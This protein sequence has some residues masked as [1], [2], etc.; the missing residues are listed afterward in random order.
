MTATTSSG[1]G[2]ER[3]KG[4]AGP[5][6]RR[7]AR[8]GGGQAAADEAEAVAEVEAEVVDTEGEEGAGPSCCSGGPEALW[9]EEEG[10]E[11]GE[12]EAEA[13]AKAPRRRLKV[14]HASIRGSIAG[15]AAF[16]S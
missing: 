1:E 9:A 6:G 15:T 7:E 3:R 10:E 8:S 13:T 12:E 11:E 5:R 4:A 14:E 16:R 2:R